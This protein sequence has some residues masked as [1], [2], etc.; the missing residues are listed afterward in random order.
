MFRKVY[1]AILWVATT[2]P[3]RQ[4]GNFSA[5]SSRGTARL[6]TVFEKEASL[7]GVIGPGTS[8]KTALPKQRSSSVAATQ[9]AHSF[10]DEPAV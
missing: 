10:V 3:A 6:E 1:F 8:A 7:T 9:E 4:I 5:P 2:P